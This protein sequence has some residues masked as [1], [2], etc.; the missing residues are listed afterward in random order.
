MSS[1]QVLIDSLCGKALHPAVTVGATCRRTGKEAVGSYLYAPE[2]LIYAAGFVPVGIWG[3]DTEIKLADRYLQ[4]FCCSIMRSDLEYGMK[5]T[6]NRLRAV[7]FPTVCDTLKCICENWKD[8]VPQVPVIP[9]VYPQNRT[10]PSAEEY[11][12]QEYLRI[13]EELERLSGQ[14]VTKESLE[15]SFALY[16]DYRNAMRDFCAAAAEHP[17]TINAKVRH[18]VIKAGY[19]M[20]KAEYTEEI[21]TLNQLLSE[22]PEETCA[23]RVVATGLMAEPVG[24]LDILNE[25]G[26]AVVADD[27]AQE[28]R[29]FRTR[30][31]TEG[32]ALSKMI[33]RIIDQRGCPFLYE[34]H[35]T[36]GGMLL[37][38]VK[39]SHADGVITL[40]MKFCDPDEFDYPIYK[41]ELEEAKIP[42]LYLEVEQQMDSFGQLRTRIQSFAEI[43]T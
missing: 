29:Q 34:E 8:A 40:L 5:G 31:R 23:V 16:E 41:K 26:I 42:Q 24:V 10:A 38:L 13:K 6:Y 17:K 27:L 39:Q 7:L 30:A 12:R 35:K 43:L 19:F 3:G 15:D 11:L 33:W 28:S 21:K 2:E 25:N 22:L 9:V 37:D 32:D 1:V 4:G 36:R 14:T 18:L 20:D